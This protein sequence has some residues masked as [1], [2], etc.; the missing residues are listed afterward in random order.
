MLRKTVSYREELMVYLMDSQPV[1]TPRCRD[2]VPAE[3]LE[4]CRG[5][6]TND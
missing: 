2:M 1:F 6:C 4:V 5:S 3:I